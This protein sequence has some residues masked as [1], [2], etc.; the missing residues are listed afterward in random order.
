VSISFGFTDVAMSEKLR[1]FVDVY[2]ALNKP[3]RK[4]EVRPMRTYRNIL[5]LLP[6]P[7]LP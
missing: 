3:S 2:T 1:H 6:E 5:Q 4:G 7:S